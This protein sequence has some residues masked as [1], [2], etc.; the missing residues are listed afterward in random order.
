MPNSESIEPARAVGALRNRVDGL[1]ITLRL[2]LISAFS[3]TSAWMERTKERRQLISLNDT[4]LKDLG[5]SRADAE[6]E[7]R[8]PFWRR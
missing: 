6:R 2:W 7:Y 3:M 4:M 8:K 5:I 1:W